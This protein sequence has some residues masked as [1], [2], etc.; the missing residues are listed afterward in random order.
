MIIVAA[1]IAGVAL[2]LGAVMALIRL[3]RGPSILDRT[4]ALDVLLII[5]LCGL[6]VDMVVN[7]HLN[8]IVFIVVGSLVAFIGSVTIARYVTDRRG[9]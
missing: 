5:I 3:A 1:W 8:H 2:A 4:L 7:R 9:Q 6:C